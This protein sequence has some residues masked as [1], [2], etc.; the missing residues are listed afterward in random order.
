MN[1]PYCDLPLDV[2]TT[3]TFKTYKEIHVI[4]ASEDDTNFGEAIVIDEVMEDGGSYFYCNSCKHEIHPDL[5]YK[6]FAELE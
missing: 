1:C 6:H 2:F 5:V 4:F 3:A